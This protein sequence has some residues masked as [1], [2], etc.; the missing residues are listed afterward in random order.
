MTKERIINNIGAE[1]V[2][3]HGKNE[4]VKAL[5]KSMRRASQKW[6]G[7]EYRT[8][9][10]SKEDREYKMLPERTYAVCLT[11][12]DEEFPQNNGFFCIIRTDDVVE[13][14]K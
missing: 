11:V 1:Q 2:L 12:W 3:F 6:N 13:D 9:V 14:L 4:E 5:F 7:P 8:Y 10:P